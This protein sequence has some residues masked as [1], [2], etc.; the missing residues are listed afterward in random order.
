MKVHDNFNF[1]KF[2]SAREN[3]GLSQI[4]NSAVSPMQRPELYQSVTTESACH[5][6][7][8]LVTDWLRV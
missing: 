5:I 8:E 3:T 2:Q 6:F 1:L 7:R 4:L